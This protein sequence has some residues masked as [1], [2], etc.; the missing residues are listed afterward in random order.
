MSEQNENVRCKV[1]IFGFIQGDRTGANPH[2]KPLQSYGVRDVSPD[3]EVL[4]TPV[5][6]A[7]SITLG[8]QAMN[9]VNDLSRI[10]SRVIDPKRFAHSQKHQCLHYLCSLDVRGALTTFH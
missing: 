7:S 8:Q 2:S 5:G 10:I 6:L 4:C 3:S 9:F 1:G